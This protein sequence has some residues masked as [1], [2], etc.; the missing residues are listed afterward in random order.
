[1]YVHTDGRTGVCIRQRHSLTGLP[2]TSNLSSDG[3]LRLVTFTL[4]YYSG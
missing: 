2:S 4:M 3:E 1:V